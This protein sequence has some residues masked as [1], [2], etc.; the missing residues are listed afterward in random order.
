LIL[1]D[2]NILLYA[3]DSTSPHHGS[4]RMWIERTLSGS[5]PVGLGWI[6]ILAFLRISTTR[7]ILKNPLSPSEAV[8][9]VSEWLHRPAVT[10]LHPGE[11]HWEIL[12]NLIVEG[13]APGPLVMDAHEAALAIEHGATLC[14][15][16]RDFTR[17][18]GLRALNPLKTH[19]RKR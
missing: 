4:A 5:E 18:P 13:Q 11:R 1:I 7:G 9:I 6:T 16:D 19:Y 3:H 14:T 2:A 8:I 15:T 10:L 17:F 12:R